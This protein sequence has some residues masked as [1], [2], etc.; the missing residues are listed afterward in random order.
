[1]KKSLLLVPFLSLTIL[2]SAIM[3]E[4]RVLPTPKYAHEKV[5]SVHFGTLSAVFTEAANDRASV[6]ELSGY[7]GKSFREGKAP[8]KSVLLLD[9]RLVSGK[10][11]TDNLDVPETIRDSVLSSPD[12]YFLKSGKG[13]I[14]ILANSKT[15]IFYA[16][17]TLLQLVEKEKRGYS[18]PVVTIADYPSL[19]MR[20][21]SDDISRGQIS[22]LAN[23]KKIIRFIAMYKMNVYMPYIEDEFDFK[24]Y[25]DFSKGR[26]PL[27]VKEVAELDKYGKLYHVRVI[28]AFE[29]LGHMEDILYKKEF[30]KYAEFPGA[31]CIDISSDSALAF[32]KNLLSEIAPAFSSKYFNMSADESFDVG[33]GA[34]KHLVDSLGIDEA[35]AQ[36]YRKVYEIL[37]SLGKKVMMYGDII[38]KNP[39]ILSEIPKDITIVDWHY[40]A[41]F[42]Y[43]SVQV[44]KNAGFP[45]LSSPAVWNF[46][47]PFPNF[48]NSYANIQ[49]FAREGYEG[50]ALGL[51]VSTWNDNG[52]AELRELNYPGYAWGAECAWNP[53]TS[54][55]AHF[56]SVFFPQYFQTKSQLPRI[57]YELLSSANNQITW[58]E[59]WRAPFVSMR[60]YNV[61]SRTE[62]IESS[63]PEVLSLIKEARNVV[64]AN[65]D[66]LDLYELS[67]KM[68]KYWADKVTG[69][70]R[71]RT[72]S[73]DSL[74]TARQREEHI[75]RIED[76]L[77]SS[78][79]SLKAEYTRLYLRTNRYP[80]LQLL[81]G[82][83]EDQEKDLKQGTAQMLAGNSNYNQLI[84][85]NFIYYPESRP[86]AREDFKID[87]ATFLKT[88]D[89]T[90]VPEHAEV[91]LIGD[92][93][94]KLFVN[95]T[96]IGDV[97]ARRTL[98]LNVERKRVQVFDVGQFLRKGANTFMVQAVNFDRF[99]SAGCNII[100]QI[101]NDTLKT[102]STWKVAKGIIS[103]DGVT[104]ARFVGA[105][106][107]DNGWTVTAP[108]F[109]L[110]LRSWIER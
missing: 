13:R 25:P 42:D 52:G 100:A 101:G 47:G 59:F 98:T 73:A 40:G 28:P 92:T 81:E 24:S 5:G 68:D 80:M 87:S 76:H 88:I 39:N 99:G 45:F 51:L 35:H 1:M 97:K 104:S 53:E 84:T 57:I 14:E 55:P 107:Y 49:Y 69:V 106:P 82:R 67:A 85:S 60:D 91:Q 50:G 8:G 9:A 72:I 54:S 110:K 74:L 75:G 56:E 33:L 31:T 70:M 30:E 58:Y 77:V 12:G 63:I 27:T 20:G 21:I 23:F 65:E 44:F 93:Y 43:P 6:D 105:R 17:A 108:D 32:M 41:S 37:K 83:F 34:S 64:G 7:F 89:L 109:S 3:A 26:A 19:K 66:I 36:Y 38:L 62:S 46:T 86:Y 2:G 90:R 16:V 71:M 96:Y 29:T 102:D 95:G 61:P 18:I 22:T 103:P 15:G 94:C 10:T 48:Y 11:S 4:V 78:V 79:A